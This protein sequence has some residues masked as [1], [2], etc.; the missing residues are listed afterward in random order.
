MVWDWA[1]KMLRGSP[2]PEQVELKARKVKLPVLDNY[3]IHHL[4]L[5]VMGM[6]QGDDMGAP[7]F[8]KVERDTLTIVICD[9]Y[10]GGDETDA[11]IM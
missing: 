8:V 11:A 10:Y 4:S 1:R 6:R 2:A 3:P 5:Q 9:S 7:G